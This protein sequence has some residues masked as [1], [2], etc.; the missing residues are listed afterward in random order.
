MSKK[1]ACRLGKKRTAA[2]LRLIRRKAAAWQRGA[3]KA[4]T[5][6]LIAGCLAEAPSQLAYA[7]MGGMGQGAMAPT[8]GVVNRAIGRL[9]DLNQN[10]PGWMYYGINAADRGLGY[11]GSY[12]TLGGFIPYAEDDLGGFWAADLRGH[13]SEYGGFFSNVGFV[14]KQFLGGSLFGV[15]VYW[16]YDGDQNQYSTAGMCGTGPF[17]QFGHSYNQVGISTEWLTDFGNLR[18]N[19]YIPVGTTAYTAGNPGSNFYQ[20]FVM[21]QY[22][23]DAALTGADLEVGAYVPGLS[24]WAGMISVGGYA[25]GNARYDWSAGSLAGKDVVPW[26]GGVY[27]RLDMTLIENWDFSLQYNNDSFFDST[28]FARL[29]YRMGGSRRRNVPDQME[30]PMMRNEH[31]VRAHQTPEVAINPTTGTPWNVIHVDNSVAAGGNGTAASPFTTLA[32]AQNAALTPFDLV[33]V[34]TG[35]SQ[36][37]AYTGSYTFQA[38]NQFLIGQGSSFTLPSVCCGPILLSTPSTIAPVL[39]NPGGPSIVLR[40]G[41]TVDH[42]VIQGSKVGISGGPLLAG[43]FPVKVNDVQILGTGAPGQRGIE[44]VNAASTKV[45]F[46]D[47]L[48]QNMTNGGLVV[49]GG[50]PNVS[51]QG[52]LQNTAGGGNSNPIIS[53]SNTAGGNVTVAQGAAPAG[54]RP[55]AVT[56]IGGGGIDILNSASDV[57]VDNLTLTKTAG[58]AIDVQNSTGTIQFGPTATITSPTDGAIYVLSSGTLASGP[59]LTYTGSITNTAGHSVEV[60]GTAGGTVE[61]TNPNGQ[62]TDSGTGILVQNLNGGNVVV[63]KFDIA[64]QAEGILVQNGTSGSAKFDTINITAAQ[65]AAVSLVNNVGPTSEFTNLNVNL[66]TGNK[67]IGFST[68][69]NSQVK[70][71]PAS[72][73][74]VDGNAALAMTNSAP[75]LVGTNTN[76]LTFVSLQSTNSAGSGITMNGIDGTLNVTGSG[77]NVA[78]SAKDGIVIQNSTALT[79]NVPGTTSSTP[80]SGDALKLVNNNQGNTSN[81]M[82]FNAVNLVAADGNGLVVTNTT[83]PALGNGLVQVNAGSIKA[84]NGAAIVANN[85]NLDVNLTSASSTTSDGDGVSIASST[86]KVSIGTTT[87]ADSAN[88]GISL[89]NN[90]VFNA[91]FGATTITNPGTAG[92]GSAAVSIVSSAFSPNVLTSFD[93]LAI[94]TTNANG[95]F[96][97][98]GGIVNFN[99]APTIAAGNGSAVDITNTAGTF[100][101]VADSG[102]R[103]ASLTSTNAPGSGVRLNHLVDNNGTGGGL[104]TVTGNTTIDGAAGPSLAF[105]DTFATASGY[106]ATFANVDITNRK[107]TGVLAQGVTDG[108]FTIGNLNLSNSNAVAG[109]AVLVQ[110]T[111]NGG[112]TSDGR[113]YILGG[114]IADAVGNGVHLINGTAWIQNTTISGATVNSI[115]AEAGNSQESTLLV[116]QSNLTGSS[117]NGV[118]GQTTGGTVNTTVRNNPSISATGAGVSMANTA[119]TIN[120]SIS[121]NTITGTPQINLDATGGAVNVEQTSSAN[122]S[123][124]NGGATVVDAGATYGAG[125]PPAPP[126]P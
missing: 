124:V 67:A 43:G 32:Q 122:L 84:T 52:T 86:G 119:G 8:G 111:Y 78:S 109:D 98:N 104:F 69:N 75:A 57:T 44:L 97:E 94:T 40:D 42:F 118:L 80:I 55:N 89:F 81:S 59:N 77:I 76:S 56:D 7:Q 125:A 16:D 114:T 25:L 18:S 15:G 112:S 123:T 82:N 4:L 30:Q 27:T 116:Q 19:G 61:V 51:F 2:R 31:I 83:S 126:A 100:A 88:N 120:T 33:Y 121:G 47:M 74:K 14:R 13:F 34:H 60:D 63:N 106:S 58:K 103:F 87:I 5:L 41:A 66:A 50:T 21:C 68:L 36:T 108:A 35:N 9:Q 20:N 26:F 23:L 12:M 85:A 11:N 53:V 22:G 90:D 39:S 3:R 96:A 99:T 62:S 65:T 49:D 73:I 48:V 105:L 113:L 93:T 17:G 46:T 38:E 29:T 6:A 71:G 54:S 91:N 10:G 110:D 102:F 28:G 95:F 117:G 64:S 115:F 92:I 1:A 70:V 72:N 45:E 101:G 24:D 79:V 107:N 37:T